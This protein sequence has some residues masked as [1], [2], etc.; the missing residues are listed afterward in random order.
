MSPNLVAWRPYS[1]GAGRAGVGP[2]K[3]A[4]GR[5]V[6][7]PWPVFAVF[8]AALAALILLGSFYNV[9]AGAVHRAESGQLLARAEAERL[10][11]CKAFATDLARGR[12]ALSTAKNVPDNAVL[13]ASYQ[14]RAWARQHQITASLD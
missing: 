6:E 14:P 10:I 11:V 2:G 9:V 3:S 7:S 8:A 1:A 12:C 5:I 4:P 13:R